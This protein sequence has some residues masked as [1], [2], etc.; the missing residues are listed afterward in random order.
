MDWFQTHGAKLLTG[1]LAVL[2]AVQGIDPAVLPDLLGDAGNRWVTF[3]V[4]VA[5]L[6]HTTFVKPP[7]APGLPPPKGLP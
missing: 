1:I 4:S 3:A 7:A 5:A 2:T 6:A